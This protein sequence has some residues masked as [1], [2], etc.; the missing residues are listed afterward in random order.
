MHLYKTLRKLVLISLAFIP[1][2]ANAQFYNRLE[3]SNSA[4]NL[5]SLPHG[6]SGDESKYS[7]G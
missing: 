4:S 5:K 6:F 2:A 1:V 3:I 7:S